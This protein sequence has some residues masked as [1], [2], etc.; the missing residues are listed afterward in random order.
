M[1][2]IVISRVMTVLT[3]VDWLYRWVENRQRFYINPQMAVPITLRVKQF[4]SILSIVW[5]NIMSV[6]MNF[7]ITNAFASTVH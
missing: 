3:V 7:M 2:M 5:S 6:V 4:G 1:G